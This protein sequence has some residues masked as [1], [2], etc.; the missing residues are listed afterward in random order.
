MGENTPTPVSLLPEALH[1]DSSML[2]QRFGPEVVNYFAG[3][4]LNRVSFL[5]G[6]RDFLKAAFAHPSTVFL[7]LDGLAPLTTTAVKK[8]AWVKR[9]DVEC[10]TGTAP[11]DKTEDDMI[12]DYNSE[13][14]HPVI[15]LLGMDDKQRL[16]PGAGSGEP[17]QHKEYKGTPYFAVDITADRALV[18]K[19][20]ARDGL[21]FAKDQRSIGL[22][23]GEGEM[24]AHVSPLL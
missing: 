16:V 6:D 5:R 15:I 3:N 4:P 10:V 14:K 13:E 1:D 8:L 21:S 7:P 12:R 11:F 20:S 17:F 22:G 2:S 19:L 9:E 18:E 23:P 24:G